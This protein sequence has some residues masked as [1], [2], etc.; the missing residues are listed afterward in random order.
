MNYYV[1]AL[2]NIFFCRTNR[3]GVE[4]QHAIGE[5][6]RRCGL[7]RQADMVL[8]RKPVRKRRIIVCSEIVCLSSTL[9]CISRV[10][11]VQCILHRVIVMGFCFW[12]RVHVRDTYISFIMISI[13][14]EF[15]MCLYIFFSVIVY[16]AQLHKYYVDVKF[17]P[18]QA[19]TSWKSHPLMILIV[20]LRNQVYSFSMLCG[21]TYR[22]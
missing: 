17:L 20:D 21:G 2:I 11:S 13:L 8:K 22:V 19:R 12:V 4:E 7:C 5:V 10:M 3:P 9:A 15:R 16:Q 6:V 18:Q 1:L 14:F